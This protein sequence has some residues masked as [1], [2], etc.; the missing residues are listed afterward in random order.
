T[1]EP[2]GGRCYAVGFV[3]DAPP[4][5]EVQSA[6]QLSRNVLAVAAAVALIGALPAGAEDLTIVSTV[7]TAKSEPKTATTYMT[8]GK[9]RHS[10]GVHDSIMDLA[11]GTMIMVDHTKK[12]YSEITADEMR[13]A[14]EKLDPQMKQ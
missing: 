1:L 3:H 12:E 9:F 7:S 2:R 6:M 4:H 14:M 10:D 8:S 5:E 13:A 11:T